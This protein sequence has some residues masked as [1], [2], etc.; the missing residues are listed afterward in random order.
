MNMQANE[1]ASL[2][3][4]QKPQP[5]FLNNAE[6]TAIADVDCGCHILSEC[7]LLAV[8][9]WDFFLVDIKN[10]TKNCSIF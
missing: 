9:L 5:I 10:A 3:K 4:I 6:S 2:K 8:Y 1:Y 7:L